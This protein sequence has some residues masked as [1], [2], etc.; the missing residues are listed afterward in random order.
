MF[1]FEWILARTVCD[2]ILGSDA[3]LDLGFTGAHLAVSTSQRMRRTEI[4]S[5][6]ELRN[7]GHKFKTLP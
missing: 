3:T 2:A 5:K 1:S 7:R 4:S 6:P